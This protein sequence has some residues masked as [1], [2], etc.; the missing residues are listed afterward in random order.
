MSKSVTVYIGLIQ[1]TWLIIQVVDDKLRCTNRLKK[2]LSRDYMSEEEEEN[3]IRKF[4][5]KPKT[6]L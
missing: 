5:R 3:F 6:A 2:Y 1:I 4:K